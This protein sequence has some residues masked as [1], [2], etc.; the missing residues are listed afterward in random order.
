MNYINDWEDRISDFNF[1]DIFVYRQNSFF[2]TKML[3]VN[4]DE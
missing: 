2:T 1:N 4:I 3:E